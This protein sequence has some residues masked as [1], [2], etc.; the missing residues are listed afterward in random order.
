MLYGWKWVPW[1]FYNSFAPEIDI[2]TH[3]DR[4]VRYFEKIDFFDFFMCGFTKYGPVEISTGV[5][6]SK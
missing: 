4:I 5:E 2:R 6:I 3:L 1:M